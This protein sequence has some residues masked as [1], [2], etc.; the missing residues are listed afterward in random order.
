[1]LLSD[2]LLPF[3]L[4][5]SLQA[6]LRRQASLP[7]VRAVSLA[8][9]V[10]T[11]PGKGLREEAAKALVDRWGWLIYILADCFQSLEDALLKSRN[12]RRR[13]VPKK[14][15]GVRLTEILIA[16]IV[17]SRFVFLLARISMSAM[18][19]VRSFRHLWIRRRQI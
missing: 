13:K 14:A 4:L 17:M 6:D 15:V 2:S 1:M 7:L 19:L 18:A 3:S 5:H 8:L 11:A 12:G 10:T 16:T 9:A